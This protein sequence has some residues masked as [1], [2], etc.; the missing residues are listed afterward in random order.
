MKAENVK[1]LSQKKHLSICLWS[2]SCFSTWDSTLHL[3]GEHCWSIMLFGD[4]QYWNYY[5]LFAKLICNKK[6]FIQ[7]QIW[8]SKESKLIKG[9]RTYQRLL[10]FSK[11]SVNSLCPA[12]GKGQPPHL[13]HVPA[14]PNS[15]ITEYSR[16]KRWTNYIRL[17]T[18]SKPNTLQ[19]RQTWIPNIDEHKKATVTKILLFYFKKKDR[20]IKKKK[21]VRWIVT[22]STRAIP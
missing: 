4:I 16:M 12:L 5:F 11:P 15:K 21:E 1:K 8:K 19:R 7:H 18:C 13:C 9:K 6:Y 10:K 2:L 20:K 22:K 14:M 17:E 3:N